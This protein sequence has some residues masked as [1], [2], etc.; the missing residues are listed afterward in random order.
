MSS[1]DWQEWK[2][3]SKKRKLSRQ[4]YNTEVVEFLAAD[5]EFPVEKIQE[6]HLRLTHEALGRLDYFPQTGRACWLPNKK[7]P[8]AKWFQISDI[9]QFILKTFKDEN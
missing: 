6:Y 5:L 4:K 2:E 3:A 8:K 9:E 1:I 7:R